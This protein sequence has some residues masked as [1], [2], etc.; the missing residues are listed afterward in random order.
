MKKSTLLFIVITLINSSLINSSPI[1]SVLLE[2]FHCKV[3]TC[4]DFYFGLINNPRREEYVD[5]CYDT[6]HALQSIPNQHGKCI[7]DQT[8]KVNP[9]CIYALALTI[10]K[11]ALA[12][13]ELGVRDANF[14]CGFTLMKHCAVIIGLDDI[15]LRMNM[16]KSTLLFIVIILINL[17]LI[18][19]APFENFHCKAATCQVFYSGLRNHPRYQEHME[20]CYDTVA[21]FQAI[22]RHFGKCYN[23][24]TRQINPTCIHAV[25]KTI[26]SCI[27]KMHDVSDIHARYYC[28][29]TLM[30]HCAG[31]VGLDR[32]PL[33]FPLR[34]LVDE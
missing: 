33:N 27:V 18:N 1:N 28:G 7:D 13:Q 11:C 24:A 26:K 17:S 29:Y 30:K 22:P 5:V 14:Y 25:A 23:E 4:R 12:L 3:A 21:T 8:G 6:V 9:P 2:N 32:F 15:P 16:K 31:N 34:R 20:T 10:K 19:S